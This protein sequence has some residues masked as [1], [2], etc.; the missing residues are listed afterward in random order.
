MENDP[1]NYDEE[2]DDDEYVPQMNYVC[3][4]FSYYNIS[5][6][7]SWNISDIGSTVLI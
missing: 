3:T 4:A 5:I 7:N 2:D 1:L 6:F